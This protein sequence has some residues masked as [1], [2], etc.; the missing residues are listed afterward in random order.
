MAVKKR[1]ATK[2]VVAQTLVPVITHRLLERVES[3]T[4]RFRALLA[5]FEDVSSQ[6]EANLAV[7]RGDNHPE[8]WLE[9]VEVEDEP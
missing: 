5:E 7:L 3:V 9:I 1:K 2:R 8:G 6:L 4:D